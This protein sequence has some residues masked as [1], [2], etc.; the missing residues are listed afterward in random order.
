MPLYDPIIP[1]R[2]AAPI[3]DLVREQRPER[4]GE[5]LSASGIDAAAVGVHRAPLT[6]AQFDRLLTATSQA[7]GRTDLGFELGMRIGVRSHEALSL[8]LRC[9]GT[10]DELLALVARYWGL[11]TTCFAV[12]YRRA[13]DVAEWTFRPAAGMSQATLFAMEELLAVSFHADCTRL[14]GGRRGPDVYLSMESPR[15][16]ARYERL[17][18]S[19]FHFGA[20]ALPEVRCVLPAAV[21]DLP[22]VQPEPAV[23][24]IRHAQLARR[25]P[26]AARTARCA[27]WV[28][29]MLREAEG[30]QPSRRVLAEL[31]DVSTRTLTRNL[32]A[33]GVNLRLLGNAIRD[34]RARAM[35][36]DRAQPITQI[37]YRLGYGDVASFTHAF[38]KTNATSP[39][40]Y[41]KPRRD[42]QDRPV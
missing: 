2:Y 4:I 16:V 33:E 22:L 28:T 41:R 27:E 5:I 12:H 24:P 9:C 23:G 35:L 29:L 42:T 34:E 39:R 18:R 32:A 10:L 38:R 37:A 17:A 11:I 26:A 20:H 31:L 3:L 21:V 36:A 15:H 6:M 25:T 30:I 13:A 14:L 7:L 8:A 40:G 19:S 1:T